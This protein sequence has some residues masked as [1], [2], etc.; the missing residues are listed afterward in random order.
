MSVEV[1]ISR[2]VQSEESIFMYTYWW[3]QTIFSAWC[4][5]I[6]GWICVCIHT[7]THTHTYIHTYCDTVLGHFSCVRLSVT[8]WTVAHQAPLSIGFSRQE[9]WS[10]LPCPPPGHLPDSGIKPASF[11]SPAL[12]GDRFFSIRA[13]W[14]AYIYLY[15]CVEG[16]FVH[17]KMFNSI[18]NFYLWDTESYPLT[19]FV[20]P[21]MS[22]GFAKYPL[23]K[24]TW[25]MNTAL[26]KHK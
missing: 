23:T 5:D 10:G 12:P 19:P 26:E 8:P 4:F 13:T 16:C 6:W 20:E 15:M 2:I 18:P 17:Y 14:E 22:P 3:L 25:L 1:F 11:M 24:C 9:S 21:K 7:H